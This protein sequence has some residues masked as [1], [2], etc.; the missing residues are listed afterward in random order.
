MR[1]FPLLFLLLPAA[2]ASVETGTDFAE[3]DF[4][5]IVEGQTT[6]RDVIARHGTPDLTIPTEAGGR[7][8]IYRHSVTEASGFNAGLLNPF[9]TD[10]DT[11]TDTETCTIEVDADGVVVRWEY[12]GP[13]LAPGA[14]AGG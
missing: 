5:W 9:S 4:Q 7:Q 3:A 12:L 1:V 2:C 8:L 11:D 10:I 6:M 14:E 13:D